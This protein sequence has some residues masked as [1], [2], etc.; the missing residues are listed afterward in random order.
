MKRSIW[1]IAL[2]L[3][4][5]G[6]APAAAQ[7][8]AAPSEPGKIPILGDIPI[9]G[10]L[11]QKKVSFNLQRVPFSEAVKF[12]FDSAGGKYLIEPGVKD[13]L[14]SVRADSLSFAEGLNLL[15]QSASHD[16][17]QRLAVA[18]RDETYVITAAAVQNA[19]LVAEVF[20]LRFADANT[21]VQE[22]RS[23]TALPTSLRIVASP[24]DNSILVHGTP[25]DL[26][27]VR[28]LVSELDTDVAAGATQLLIKIE[29]VGQIG[30][31]PFSHTSSL[32]AAAGEEASV[33]DEAVGGRPTRLFVVLKPSKRNQDYV[34]SGTWQ[35][36]IPVPAK[37]GGFVQL[38][39]RIG[40]TTHVRP[41]VRTRIGAVEAKQWEGDGELGFF[42]TVTPI[43]LSAN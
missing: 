24:R 18:R 8:P 5:L 35:I 12:L 43:P 31:K 27:F 36:S 22:I 13:P 28:R 38:E 25:D 2:A 26:G 32:S 7:A 16:G 30:A 1:P 34:V 10:A 33:Q 19:D 40:T 29:V 21:L 41:G 3:A 15:M 37:G 23:G 6:T 39:K 42:L 9:L 4:A 11:F 14:I 20:R 17:G